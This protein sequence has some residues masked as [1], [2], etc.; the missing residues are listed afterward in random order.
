MNRERSERKKRQFSIWGIKKSYVRGKVDGF[1]KVEQKLINLYIEHTMF[2]WQ[3][4]RTP[5]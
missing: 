1:L 2:N 5:S 3:Q 4:N